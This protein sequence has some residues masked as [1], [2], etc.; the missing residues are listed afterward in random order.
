MKSNQQPSPLTASDIPDKERERAGAA[1]MPRLAALAGQIIEARKPGDILELR[2][3]RPED[4]VSDRLVERALRTSADYVASYVIAVAK[5]D[6][7]RARLLAEGI[8]VPWVRPIERANGH[9]KAVVEVVRLS[10][11]LTNHA[12]IIGE[13]AGRIGVRRLV[14]KKR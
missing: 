5:A 1:E 6:P 4:I 10:E 11:Y 9:S 7:E 14:K 3:F 8:E 12:L 2:A 13:T